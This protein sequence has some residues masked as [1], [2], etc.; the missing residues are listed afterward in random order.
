[1]RS[2]VRHGAASFRGVLNRWSETLSEA[3]TVHVSP[4]AILWLLV[5]P[6]LLSVYVG[7]KLHNSSTGMW[8]DQYGYALHQPS[9]DRGEPQE[10]RSDE[11]F[12]HTPTLLNQAQTGMKTFNPNI[13]PPGATLVN[14]VPVLHPV[15][16]ANPQFWGYVLFDIEHGFSWHWGVRAI[17]L[18]GALFG[19]LLLLTRGQ[20]VVAWAGA[21]AIFGS[22]QVQ[23]W[24]ASWLTEIIAGMAGALVGLFLWANSPSRKV[25]YGAGI[26]AALCGMHVIS[27][28]YLPAVMSL[29]FLGMFLGSAI[30]WE[31][32]QSGR[33][34]QLGMHRWLALGVGLLFFAAIFWSFYSVARP[35]IDTILNTTYPGKRVV[36]GGDIAWVDELVG[37]FDF[38]RD[39][40]ETPILTNPSE[41]A[42][43]LL[44]YPLVALLAIF[45]VRGAAT[46]AMFWSLVAYCAMAIVWMH[47]ALPEPWESWFG[48]IG[49]NKIPSFRMYSGLGVASWIMTAMVLAKAAEQPEDSR[50]T[51]RVSLV[52]LLLTAMAVFLA[53]KTLTPINPDYYTIERLLVATLVVA[54][55]LWAVMRGNRFIFLAAVML[56]TWKPLLINPT[57]SGLNRVLDKELSH[58]AEALDP[59]GKE[60]WVVMQ[61]TRMSQL[62]RANGHQVISGNYFAPRF[63]LMH[64][65]DP[66]EQY[67]SWWNNYGEV[68]FEPLADPNRI[69]FRLGVSG[70]PDVIEISPCN[71]AYQAIGITRVVMHERA[72][73]AEYPCL[74]Q[75]AEF[76]PISVFIY[77]RLPQ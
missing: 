15:L 36:S 49:L 64:H 57:S 58:R 1:H 25:A 43:P 66:D 50:P 55:L 47:V 17:S 38:W 40:F 23:W 26:L 41:A 10:I 11:W 24:Y 22:S 6:L 72:D 12:V 51:R 21:L 28:P 45:A 61:A 77:E 52:V 76:E 4:G 70:K 35:A 69:H 42:R 33:L 9:F 48:R 53:W 34:K 59:E 20:T 75:L 2:R 62:L 73:L 68:H 16:L 63:E 5:L 46:G 14:G 8:A 29:A 19:L 18:L 37:W 7:L 74:R 3:T 65:F 67:R 71:P 44:I 30:V 56:V 54:P 39:K 13:G 32:H 31:S 27:H 60:K